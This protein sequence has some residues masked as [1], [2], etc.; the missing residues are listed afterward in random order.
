MPEL[1][2]LLVGAWLTR[3][4]A[5]HLVADWM[6]RSGRVSYIP[7]DYGFYVETETEDGR[8]LKALFRPDNM[9][10]DRDML[11][12]YCSGDIINDASK[13][14]V[15][16]SPEVA[17]WGPTG[18][19]TTHRNPTI[20]VQREAVA[21]VTVPA[22]GTTT[23]A[24]TLPIARAHLGDLYQSTI[25]VLSLRSSNRR[26]HHFRLGTASFYGEAFAVWPERAKQP[27][28]AFKKPR[29]R[30]VIQP[31]GLPRGGGP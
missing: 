21:T 19:A 2:V 11:P 30:G 31:K 24:V 12:L 1:S 27:V 15:L 3:E 17:F 8:M 4:I 18:L 13:P 26:Q 29:S 25:P 28:Y 23:V 14:L 9:F 6:A 22:H 7:R 20:H 10:P 16:H 5:G